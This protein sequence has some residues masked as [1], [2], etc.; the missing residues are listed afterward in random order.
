MLNVL[1]TNHEPLNTCDRSLQGD[2]RSEANP[3]LDQNLETPT[4]DHYGRRPY[5]C[6]GSHFFVLP[7]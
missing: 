2:A 4:D 1:T 6:V 3:A 7:D 5:V